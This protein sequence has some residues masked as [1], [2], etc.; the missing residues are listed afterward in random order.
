M[1][2]CR[3]LTSKTAAWIVSSRKLPPTILWKYFGLAP[4]FRSRRSRSASTSSSVT[5]IPPS[6]M[7]PRFFEGK[8]EKH[9]MTPM[10]P[11]ARLSL[12]R[13][14]MACAASSITGT[15]TSVASSRILAMSAHWP[16]RCTGTMAF[17]RC[18]TD[19]SRAAH[20]FSRL[21]GL[22]LRLRAL[23]DGFDPLALHPVPVPAVEAGR[24]ATADGQPH[25]ALTHPARDPRGSPQHQ[26][27]VGYILRDHGP[28][29]DEGIA[30]NGMPAD[31]GRV[32]AKGGPAAH[33]GRPV[34][35]LAR[36]V[37]ARVDHVGEDHGG[38]AEDIVLENDSLVD[39]HVVLDLDV[40]ADHDVAGYQHIL[41]EVAATPDP[42]T[43]HDVA[44]VPDLRALADLA[45][46]VDGGGGVREIARGRGGRGGA[47]SDRRPP[48]LERLLAGLEHPQHLHAVPPVGP[49]PL[50]R[51]DA[52]E[53][54]AALLGQRLGVGQRDGLGLC[55]DRHRH[56]LD[57]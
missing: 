47:K 4:W 34:L 49:G 44:V 15:F 45:A 1:S 20:A 17:T 27:V 30:P 28:G 42:R 25:P 23:R 40:V 12:Y 35:V 43:W 5:T 54:V 32:G 18:C 2:R 56:T 3:S 26:G 50:A 22:M 8:K 38:A 41:P 55:L 48:A 52:L 33:Q 37:A 31:D 21:V 46:G 24:L 6:P 13:V 19:R 16:K 14:P 7:A 36:D 11:A 53:E 51:R 57:P 9:P 29:A 10:V 39:R